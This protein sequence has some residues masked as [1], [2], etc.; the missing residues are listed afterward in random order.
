[1]ASELYFSSDSPKQ[2][3][4]ITR[5]LDLVSEPFSFCPATS[6]VMVLV[7]DYVPLPA[8][9]FEEGREL[10][11][12][13]REEGSRDYELAGR[14]RVFL[15]QHTSWVSIAGSLAPAYRCH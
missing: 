9:T 14:G 1:M 11:L 15:G 10:S 8:G 5:C 6:A 12:A 4:I 3:Q 2:Q 13:G 7:E